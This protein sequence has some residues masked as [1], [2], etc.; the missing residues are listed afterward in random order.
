MRPSVLKGTRGKRGGFRFRRPWAMR[1]PRGFKPKEPGDLVEVDTLSVTL[2]PGK[3]IKQFTARDVVSGWNVLEVFLSASSCCGRRFLRAMFSRVPFRVKAIKVDGGSEFY[4][5][6]EKEC[7]ERG[8][9][10]YVVRPRSPEEQGYVE[11]AQGIHRYEFYESYDLPLDLGELRQVVREWEWICN[12]LRPSRPLGG[13]TPW[14]YLM[15]NHREEV[16]FDA[17]L[18]Q[19]YRTPRGCMILC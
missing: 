1:W 19:M 5:E 13:K 17:K 7:Q 12:F 16:S 18:S 8:V 9:R 10:L 11:R 3:V 6:F 15:E 2:S 4:G 14:E